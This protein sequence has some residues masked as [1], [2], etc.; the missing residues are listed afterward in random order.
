MQQEFFYNFLLVLDSH[1]FN[2]HLKAE[3]AG[4]ITRLYEQHTVAE[5]GRNKKECHE[6]DTGKSGV[7]EAG[8]CISSEVT[9]FTGTMLK[10][11]VCQ[12]ILFGVKLSLFI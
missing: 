5:F 4:E 12:L 10:L 7:N 3:L 8:S 2:V 6:E 11:Q 9:G 1:A